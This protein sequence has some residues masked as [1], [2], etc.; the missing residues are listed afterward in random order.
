MTPMNNDSW[1]DRILTGSGIAGLIGRM[2]VLAGILCAFGVGLALEPQLARALALAIFAMAAV[3]F[4]PMARPKAVLA[5]FAVVAVGTYA[6][7]K[8]IDAEG[9]VVVTMTSLFFLG[10]ATT[11]RYRPTIFDVVA[12]SIFSAVALSASQFDWIWFAINDFGNTAT[13]LAA[14]FGDPPKRWSASYS[15]V[16]PTILGLIHVVG[17]AAVSKQPRRIAIATASAVLI[18]FPPAYLLAAAAWM[19]G[20]GY[21]NGSLGST[22]VFFLQWSVIPWIA[23]VVHLSATRDDGLAIDPWPRVRPQRA[24]AAA[25][26]AG[27]VALLTGAATTPE[28]EVSGKGRVLFVDRSG[29]L[30]DYSVP[31][32]DQLGYGQSGLYGQLIRLLASTGRESTI[33]KDVVDDAL[34]ANYKTI[35]ITVPTRAFTESEKDVLHRFVD[36]GGGLLLL[37]DHTD[38]FGL[39]GPSNALLERYG[40]EVRFD[41][42]MESAR[43]LLGN[44]EIRRVGAL[45]AH[46]NPINAQILHGASLRLSRGARPWIVG[47]AMFGDFGNRQNGGNGGYL[48]DY[49]FRP[50]E[51][52]AGDLVLAAVADSGEGRVV[53]FGDTSSFQN[54]ALARSAS[55]V[56]DVF[57]TLERRSILRD[58]VV[59]WGT[60]MIAAAVLLA[61]RFSTLRSVV[62]A[63][64]VVGHVLLGAFFAV[65]ESRADNS[66]I[67][68]ELPPRSAFVLHTGGVPLFDRDQFKPRSVQGLLTTSARVDLVGL[69]AD[70]E[71]IRDFLSVAV[72]C[73]G[74]SARRPD[75]DTVD[76]LEQFVRDGGIVLAAAGFE[77]RYGVEEFLSRFGMSI[78]DVP[79]SAA[80]MMTLEQQR[81][82][83]GPIFA[84]AWPIAAPPDQSTETIHEVDGFPIVVKRRAGRGCVVAVGDSWFLNDKNF[85]GESKSNPMNVA[86]MRTAIFD[87]LAK[88]KE[89]RR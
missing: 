36:R 15:A 31:T 11:S 57:A 43:S 18:L 60:I 19:R 72:V 50:E 67:L 2:L 58:R 54:V 48:G 22:V 66:R 29:P 42:V 17:Q 86:L 88:A 13:R 61:A 49:I 25:S 34:V 85:E 16:W 74:P 53:A 3:F 77:E 37:L 70:V 81:N 24:I 71:E 76:R 82:Y 33:S 75:R 56:N 14:L 5:A 45:P 69:T 46:Q 26:A 20:A 30:A 64:A 1:R 65:D 62:P 27:V 35:V 68:A 89:E 78:V 80:P 8:S 44:V 23:L 10:S 6:V 38:L 79:L 4:R 39:A 84:E 41:T 87:S 32:W 59:P 63:I 12:L 9:A 73:L 47:R 7:R 52:A 40:I 28:T 83:K 51:E 21:S 55:F